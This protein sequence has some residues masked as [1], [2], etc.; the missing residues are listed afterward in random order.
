MRKAVFLDRDGVINASKGFVS[1]QEEVVLIENIFEALKKIKDKG[2][3]LIVVTNQPIVARGLAS[4]EDIEEI[5]DFMNKQLG[6]LI[7]N[8]YLCPHHPEMHDDVPVHARKYRIKCDCRKPLPGMLLRAAKKFELDLK[9]SWMIGDMV[10]DIIAG[11]AAGCKTILVKSDYT[12]HITKTWPLFDPNVKSDFE[13]E[14]LK[15]AANIIN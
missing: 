11:K 9:E 15:E 8:F 12:E 5:H 4:E 10:T 14:N 3:L 2:F 6:G 1:K 7:D 13:V